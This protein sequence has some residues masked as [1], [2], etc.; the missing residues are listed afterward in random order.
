MDVMRRVWPAARREQA[1]RSA[2]Y[3]RVL[4]LFLPALAQDALTRV[5]QIV[6]EN[7]ARAL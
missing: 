7:R 6:A 4:P 5:R 3:Y 1:I 2:L